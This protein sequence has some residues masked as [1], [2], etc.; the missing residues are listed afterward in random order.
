MPSVGHSGKVMDNVLRHSDAPLGFL[1]AA[2]VPGGPYLELCVGDAGIGIHRSLSRAHI[3]SSELDAITLAVKEN[4]SG[5][6]AGHAGNGLFGLERLAALNEGDL[7]I[8]SG[9]ASLEIHGGSEPLTNSDRKA[10]S[11]AFPGTSVHVQTPLESRCG[12][13]ICDRH[14]SSQYNYRVV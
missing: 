4:V 7:E 14:K 12:C 1:S 3:V 9:R 11:L 6:G 13:A 2:I 10:L 5:A 8:V